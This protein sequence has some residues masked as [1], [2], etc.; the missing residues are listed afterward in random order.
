MPFTRVE[1]LPWKQNLTRV[2]RDVQLQVML[3]ELVVFEDAGEKSYVFVA[4]V[5]N[6]C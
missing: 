1:Y 5:T 3:D 4:P 6:R 2:E